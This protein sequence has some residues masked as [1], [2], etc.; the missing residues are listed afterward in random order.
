MKVFLLVAILSTLLL[1]SEKTCYNV[2]LFSVSYSKDK[3]EKLLSQDIP[4]NCKVLH[5]GQNLALR[6]GCYDDKIIANEYLIKAKKRYKN[7]IVTNSYA[8]RFGIIDKKEN[9]QTNYSSNKEIE[10]LKNLLLKQVQIDAKATDELK[11][12]IKDL[13]SKIDKQNKQIESL[14]IQLQNQNTK[15]TQNEKSESIV[16]EQTD[17]V[18]VE[19]STP[20]DTE[21]KEK[22]VQ[23]Q[24]TEEQNDDVVIDIENE[25]VKPSKVDEITEELEEIQF[26]IEE[27]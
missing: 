13:E 16:E 24:I 22:D 14:T 5:I 6:C 17:D 25:D 19:L 1:S 21:S 23:V 18:Q 3:E 26:E 4:K 10:E 2:Q 15:I 11:T 7:A 20:Q 9:K 27:F 8:Y 12:M